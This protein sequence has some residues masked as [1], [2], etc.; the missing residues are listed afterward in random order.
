MSSLSLEWIDFVKKLRSVGVL[1]L[2]VFVPYLAF[3]IIPII[4]VLTLIAIRDIKIINQ[5]LND[6]LLYN[7]YSKYQTAS[8]VKFI[9][10]I[11]VHLGAAMLAAVLIFHFPYLFPY[12]GIP[13][14]FFLL[15]I[16]FIIMILGSAVEVGAWDNLKFFIQNHKDLFPARNLYDTTTSIENLRTGAFLWALGFLIIPIVIGWIFQL[17]GYFTLS[18]ITKWSMKYEPIT[19]ISQNLKPISTTPQKIQPVSTSPPEA[20]LENIIKFCPM[21]GARISEGAIYC[22]ECGVNLRS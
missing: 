15:I 18:N 7:F 8:I 1:L 20:E 5:E 11:V 16:G 21:C 13:P 6:K 10:S 12:N 14:A 3:I 22:G 19:P 9:G 2:F 4:F 17:I